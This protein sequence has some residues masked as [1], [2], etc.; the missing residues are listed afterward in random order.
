MTGK[1]GA[2]PV[3]SAKLDLFTIS[4]RLAKQ[5]TT[6]STP[7]SFASTPVAKI[8]AEASLYQIPLGVS[9]R[10]EAERWAVSLRPALLLNVV[11]AD[12]TRTEVLANASGKVLNSWKDTGSDT[13][14]AMG[15]G[16]F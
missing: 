12:A 6:R 9:L 16:A 11:D 2:I 10:C 13:A 14:F 4:F 3:P 8:E 7:L 15:A 1:G 5:Q